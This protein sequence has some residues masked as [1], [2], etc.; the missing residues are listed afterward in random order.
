MSPRDAPSSD[1]W[2]PIST[3]HAKDNRGSPHLERSGQ[4][5]TPSGIL[6]AHTRIAP[7]FQI[8]QT[9]PNSSG[10][11]RSFVSSR[12]RPLNSRELRISSK[13]MDKR[14]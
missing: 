12:T 9:A 8:R 5:E 6:E 7:N 14:L 4:A 1:L 3:N 11:A 10:F 13:P 2:K